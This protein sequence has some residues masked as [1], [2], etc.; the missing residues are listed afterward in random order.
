MKSEDPEVDTV[1]RSVQEK[2]RFSSAVREGIA[3]A[4]RGELID[5]HEVHLWLEQR[6]RP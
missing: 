2:Q 3:Q 6:E 1:L 4:D 5:D